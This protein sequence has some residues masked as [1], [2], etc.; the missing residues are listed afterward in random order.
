M[1][2]KTL[3]V[4]CSKCRKRSEIMTPADDHPSPVIWKCPAPLENGVDMCGAS[5]SLDL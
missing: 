1:A 5:N 4:T 3:R 2:D